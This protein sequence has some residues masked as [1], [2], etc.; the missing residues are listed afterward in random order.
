MQAA[1]CLYDLL[2]LL[3]YML[4]FLSLVMKVTI[5]VKVYLQNSIELSIYSAL[6]R[7]CY[8]YVSPCFLKAYICP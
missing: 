5:L 7:E 1:V 4:L 6:F 2:T 8:S 3:F